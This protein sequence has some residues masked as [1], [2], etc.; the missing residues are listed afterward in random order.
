MFLGPQVVLAVMAVLLKVG[1]ATVPVQVPSHIPLRLL[2]LLV[3]EKQGV[4]VEAVSLW[5]NGRRL[6]DALTV[7]VH[8]PS[9]ASIEIMVKL[10]GGNSKPPIKVLLFSFHSHC[11]HHDIF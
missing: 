6:G 1:G 11:F 3:A 2:R 7:G 9:N 8:I 4:P 5:Y 10:P